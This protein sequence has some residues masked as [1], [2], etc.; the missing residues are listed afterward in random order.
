MRGS[1]KM[2]APDSKRAVR[3]EF[4][5]L[6]E[7]HRDAVFRLCLVKLNNDEHTA[8]DCTQNTFTV[9]YQKLL[10]GEK[11][12][13]P[14]AF[15]YKTANNFILKAIA[16]NTHATETTLPIESIND[17]PSADSSDLEEN[18]DYELLKRRIY[19]VLTPQEKELFDLRF[20]EDLTLEATADR[21]S[22]S[23]AA[24]AKRL[25]RMRNKIINSAIT[26]WKGE[27]HD[28]E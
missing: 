5:R 26:E 4:T 24:V 28:D 9:L 8:N 12:E 20:I 17:E 15:L 27:S 16:Q 7:N 25:E 21:L 10:D 22:I 11:I 23:K 1:E 19:Q 18:I 3:D 6:Y 2:K 14:N 13:Y